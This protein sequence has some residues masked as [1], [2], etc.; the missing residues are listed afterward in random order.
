MTE[1]FKYTGIG[2]LKKYFGML[3]GQKL[4]DFAD[5]VK[6]LS[7]NDFLQLRAGIIDGTLDYAP[8]QNLVQ[9]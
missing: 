5:E 7:P 1:A 4:S 2:D 8:G 6:K 9:A 3:P